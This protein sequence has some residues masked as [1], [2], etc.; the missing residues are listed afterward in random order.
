[1]LL[2]IQASTA[3]PFAH[4]CYA[5]SLPQVPWRAAECSQAGDAPRARRLCEVCAREHCCAYMW[6]LITG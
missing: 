3:V 6:A 5:C 2:K 1:M 4:I